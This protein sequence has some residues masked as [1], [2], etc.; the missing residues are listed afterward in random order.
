LVNPVKPKHVFEIIREDANKEAVD[1]WGSFFVSEQRR[2][3]QDTL[4]SRTWSSQD[5]GTSF[6]PMEILDP[7]GLSSKDE[8]KPPPLKRWD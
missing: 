5:Y 7:P 2:L 1:S 4:T 8:D 6:Q 3:S